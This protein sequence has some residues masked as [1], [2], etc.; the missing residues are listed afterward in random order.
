MPFRLP[1]ATLL[2]SIRLPSFLQE[3]LALVAEQSRSFSS[4]RIPRPDCWW[5][6]LSQQEKL[7]WS[8]YIFV[9]ASTNGFLWLISILF[10][11][12]ARPVYVSRWA[13]ILPGSVNAVNLN[14]PDIG[15]ASASS[16]SASVAT[17]TFDPRDNYEYIFTSQQVIRQAASNARLPPNQF[18]EPRIKNIDNTTLMQFEVTGESPQEARRKSYALYD[19][20][21]QRLNELR[22]SEIE[23]RQGPTQRILLDTQAKLSAA[24]RRVSAYKLRSGINSTEQVQT[25]STNI[26]QLRRQRAE[27]SSQQAQAQ[28]SVQKL[29]RSL[30]LTADDAADAFKLQ[31]D[32]IFQQN[33]KDYSEATAILKVQLSK[34]GS[35]HP[36]ITKEIKRQQAAR[37]AMQ[38]QARQILGRPLQPTLLYRLALS[39]SGTG[40][41]SL[42]QSLVTGQS[43]AVGASAQVQKLDQQISALDA[44]LLRMSQRQSALENLKLDEQIAEAVLSSTLAKL[45]LT[46]ADLF[47][48]FPLVQIAV[49]PSLDDQPT[50]PNR[51]LVLAGCALGSTFITIGLWVL[52]IR[53][54]WIR[55][56]AHWVSK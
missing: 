8:R 21:R 24:Q 33:L 9:S 49:E 31:V 32:Q 46:Q 18:G 38:R 53:K 28:A 19:A 3:L 22:T 16:G 34:F 12:F 1:F 14:L 45:D 50:S 25:L 23:Q 44:R 7:R 42:F 2:A 41:D 40:R 26:E 47:A 10:L 29:S 20:I 43:T 37:S 51:S 17:S 5:R 15:Q 52:W 54:P 11:L 55:R 36:R 27:Y 39:G 48:A 4:F 30:G 6:Q 56:I 13:L 35:N